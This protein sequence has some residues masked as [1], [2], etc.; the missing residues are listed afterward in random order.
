[1]IDKEKYFVTCKVLGVGT[2]NQYIT[3][4]GPLYSLLVNLME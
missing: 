1:M 4:S 2:V 3:V